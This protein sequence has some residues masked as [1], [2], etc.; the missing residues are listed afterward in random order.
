MGFR[1][2]SPDPLAK[3]PVRELGVWPSGSVLSPARAVRKVSDGQELTSPIPCTA[4]EQRDLRSFDEPSCRRDQP[5][6]SVGFPIRHGGEFAAWEEQRMLDRGPMLSCAKF[7][8]GYALGSRSSRGCELGGGG[9]PPPRAMSTS[10]SSSR[11]SSSVS[12]S[13][14][15]VPWVV[16]SMNDRPSPSGSPRS[17]T[18]AAPEG[19]HM[20]LRELRSG[21]VA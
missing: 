5:E 1:S 17:N 21:R 6:V 4:L 9:H 3:P 20:V 12:G 7:A 15:S 11:P 16:S 19:V 10:V 8:F 18:Y 13:S 2:D 14:G